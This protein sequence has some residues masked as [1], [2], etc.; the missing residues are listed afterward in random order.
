M[1][2]EN[3]DGFENIIKTIPDSRVLLYNVDEKK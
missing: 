2:A 3:L 1:T